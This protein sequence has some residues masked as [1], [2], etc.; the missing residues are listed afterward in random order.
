[1]KS[2]PDSIAIRAAR[3]MVAWSGSSPVSR[4]TLSRPARAL[5]QLGHGGHEAP[6]ER[7]RSPPISA[8]VGQ[9]DVDLVGAVGQRADRLVDGCGDVCAPRPGS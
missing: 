2:A 6:G 7:R 9:H 4:I 8:R 3:A 5:D 1:M